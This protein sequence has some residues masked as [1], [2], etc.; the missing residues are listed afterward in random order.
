[1]SLEYQNKDFEEL[2]EEIVFFFLFAQY[3]VLSTPLLG[4]FK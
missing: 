4:H 3:S 1:M 2:K